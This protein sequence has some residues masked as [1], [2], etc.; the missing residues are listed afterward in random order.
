MQEISEVVLYTGD[1][2]DVKL[3][4]F[5]ENQDL[6]LSQKMMGEL[7]DV[8][9]NTVNYHI[10]EIYKSKE[11]EEISITRKFRVVQTV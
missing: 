11:L 4:V 10:R 2:G 5:L 1:N 7:F 9:S 3:K 6:W 8:E